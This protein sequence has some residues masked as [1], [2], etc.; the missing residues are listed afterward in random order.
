MMPKR[1][2]ATNRATRPHSRPDAVEELCLSRPASVPTTG[3]SRTTA[4]QRLG[5]HFGNSPREPNGKR[6]GEA[7][8]TEHQEQVEP[9]SREAPRC[10]NPDRDLARKPSEFSVSRSRTTAGFVT[11]G[12]QPGG[13]CPQASPKTGSCTRGPENTGCHPAASSR[14]GSRLFCPGGRRSVMTRR[15]LLLPGQS[16]HP[17]ADDRALHLGSAGP[18]NR[19]SLRPQPLA[20]PES[21]GRGLSSAAPPPAATPAPITSSAAAAESALRTCRTTRASSRSTPARGSMP[22]VSLDSV[23]PVVQPEHAQ[24]HE[25]TVRARRR[26]ST[27]SSSSRAQPRAA[28]AQSR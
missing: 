13:A 8:S 6:S 16:Q 5:E 20:L 2:G 21:R 7:S 22:L 23:P 18:A 1:A 12:K 14:H 9:R 17:L 19:R 24:I 15:F 27:S 10:R 4:V 3:A 26:W 28:R 11:I 25:M